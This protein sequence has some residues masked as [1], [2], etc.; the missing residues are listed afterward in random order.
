MEDVP[1]I[2]CRIAMTAIASEA[3][4]IGISDR[5]LISELSAAGRVFS[6]S[7]GSEDIECFAILLDRIWPYI[8]AHVWQHRMRALK[9]Q[10]LRA[11]TASCL[12][13][14]SQAR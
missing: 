12:S 5:K 8:E 13:E 9:S 10:D 11:T 6:G 3:G 7:V 14:R 4:N 1:M 2:C